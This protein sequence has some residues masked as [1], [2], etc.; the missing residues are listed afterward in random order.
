MD[1]LKERLA[2]ELVDDRNLTV[3]TYNE[4]L[5]QRIFSHLNNY[6]GLMADWL[7]M[8]KGEVQE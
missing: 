3:H 6:A 1:R 8:M 4:E 5:A 2:L 7:G